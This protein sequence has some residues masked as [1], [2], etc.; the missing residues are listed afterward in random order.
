MNVSLEAKCGSSLSVN[1]R[2][3]DRRLDKFRPPSKL[4]STALRKLLHC[5][6]V[7]LCL[8]SFLEICGRHFYFFI[9]L[10]FSALM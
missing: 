4:N 7:F 5:G 8:Y 2:N 6:G 3:L 1:R 10:S 9:P